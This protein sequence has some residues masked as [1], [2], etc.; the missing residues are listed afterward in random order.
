MTVKPYIKSKS[1]KKEQIK[2]MFD[3]IAPKYDFLNHFLSFGTDRIWRNKVYK[4]LAKQFS[5]SKKTKL[6]LDI[7]T[8]TGDLAIEL[9]KI[10][11]VK[12][13]GIDISDKML[14]K[15]KKKVCK[16]NLTNKINFIR[17]DAENMDSIESKFD[18]ITVAFGVRNFENL[19]KGLKEINRV[20]KKEGVFIVL[21][22][23]KPSKFPFKQIYWSYFNIFLPIIG[24]L[25]SKDKSAY[26]YLPKSVLEFP[27]K[28]SFLHQ[29][30][31]AGFKNLSYKTISLGIT[32]VYLAH[33][34]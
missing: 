4:I 30:S 5:N 27:E 19:Q 16:K 3:N 25:I 15:A 2:H 11:N 34:N 29:L 14:L 20:L 22:F 1:G 8:G 21:E 33:K 28:E 18:A 12:I 10:K 17:L 31:L 7:A 32:T 13:T 24:K 23:S 9:S 26:A 6:I